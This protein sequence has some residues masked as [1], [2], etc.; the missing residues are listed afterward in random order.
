MRIR[1]HLNPPEPAPAC[2]RDHVQH[3]GPPD[4][5]PHPL[6]LDEQILDLEGVPAA[7]PA[8]EAD[9]LTLRDRGPRPPL[10]HRETRKLQH[11]GMRQ[12]VRPVFLVGQR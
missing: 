9:D 12:Q 3:Q 8:S 10:S 7:E 11:P 2:D 5:T 4:P 6:G 1:G